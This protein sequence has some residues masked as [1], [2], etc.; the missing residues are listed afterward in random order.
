MRRI[1]LLSGGLAAI[2]LGF[3]GAYWSANANRALAFNGSTSDAAERRLVETM[4]YFGDIYGPGGL[5]RFAPGFITSCRVRVT[6]QLPGQ[7]SSGDCG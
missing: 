7:R 3:Y 4:Q 1:P 5:E 6:S 2:S